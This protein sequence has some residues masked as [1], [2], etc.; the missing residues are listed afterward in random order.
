MPTAVCL[1]FRRQGFGFYG[2]RPVGSSRHGPDAFRRAD[3]QGHTHSGVQRGAHAARFYLRG[4]HRGGGHADLGGPPGTKGKNEPLSP[5]NADAPHRV[6]NIGNGQPV[7]LGAFID[8]L[9]AALGVKAER[10]LEPMQ[11][12][13]VPATHADV[14]R[15][16]KDFG[17]LPHTPLADGVAAFASWYKAISDTDL[18]G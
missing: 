18:L 15:F 12:G 14:G 17:P 13:D 7:W 10:I 11:P 6:Y 16:E 3:A 4:R 1:G 9:E 5:A 8:T 2:L